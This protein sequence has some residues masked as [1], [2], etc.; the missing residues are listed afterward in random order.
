[1]IGWLHGQAR[2]LRAS[3]PRVGTGPRGLF[4]EATRESPDFSPIHSSMVQMANTEHFAHPG[5]FRDAKK[6]RETVARA[7]KAVELDPVDSRAH[8]CLGWSYAFAFQYDAAV[9]HMTLAQELNANDPGTLTS[10]AG[11]WAFCGETEKAYALAHEA[12]A[13]SISPAPISLDLL[14]DGALS[15]R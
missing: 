6:A 13:A 11:F 12:I 2:C 14:R 9:L 3:T 7:K 10:T 1:M 5:V 15:L 8:L 4:A